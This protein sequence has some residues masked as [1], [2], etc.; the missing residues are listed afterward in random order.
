[1][2]KVFCIITL[3]AEQL[4]G[5]FWLYQ[6]KFNLTTQKVKSLDQIHAVTGTARTQRCADDTDLYAR[7][8]KQINRQ[9]SA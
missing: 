5:N 2:Q 1:M 9:K 3:Y 7:Y 6:H 8:E 4:Y